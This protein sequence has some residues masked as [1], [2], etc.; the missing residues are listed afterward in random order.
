MLNDINLRVKPHIFLWLII[1][2]G[3]LHPDSWNY[4]SHWRSV[5]LRNLPFIL[6]CCLLMPCYEKSLNAYT[7]PRCYCSIRS[8]VSG[9]CP[10]PAQS[11]RNDGWARHYFWPLDASPLCYSPVPLLDTG[12]G[13]LDRITKIAVDLSQKPLISSKLAFGLTRGWTSPLGASACHS[14]VYFWDTTL[15]HPIP[16]QCDHISDTIN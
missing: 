15:K 6:C 8:L 2:V 7:I 14:W 9:L 5:A 13:R 10:L 11:Q 12:I 3:P 16:Y 1:L 4:T